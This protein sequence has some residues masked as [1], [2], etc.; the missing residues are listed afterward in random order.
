MAGTFRC[1]CDVTRRVRWLQEELE[2]RR[3]AWPHRKTG[4]GQGEGLLSGT[5]RLELRADSEIKE[6]GKGAGKAAGLD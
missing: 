1:G 6:P 5:A 4:G 3:R 2:G